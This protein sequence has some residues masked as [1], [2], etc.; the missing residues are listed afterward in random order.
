VNAARNIRLA[1]AIL[2]LGCLSERASVRASAE[3]KPPLIARPTSIVLSKPGQ[4]ALSPD[5]DRVAISD[6]FGNS[7]QVIDSRGNLVWAAGEGLA[8]NQPTAVAFAS[9]GDV[10]YSQWDGHLVFRVSQKSVNRIDTVAD[11]SKSAGPASRI[12]KIY[13]QPDK[14]WLVLTS[15]PDQLVRFDTDFKTPAVLVKGGSSKGKIDRPTGVAQTASGRL[16]VAARGAN[17]VQIFDQSGKFLVAADWNASTPVGIWEAAAV[18]VD[19]RERVWAFDATNIRLR[20]YDQTGTLLS[21]RGIS[22]GNRFPVDMVI[23]ADNQLIV[24]DANGRID[25]YDLN[26]EN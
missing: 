13:L 3:E 25:L 26:L 16:V 11:L 18:T 23:T 7:I 6:R 17:P 4:A 15:N 22:S 10:L 20:E 8:L 14:A 24:I 2:S 9:S 12:L 21:T 1:I 5:G 19:T